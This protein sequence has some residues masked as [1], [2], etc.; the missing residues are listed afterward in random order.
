MA[1]G[2]RLGRRVHPRRARHLRRRV[3]PAAV[4]GDTVVATGR[5]HYR[6]CPTARSCAPSRTA[7]SCASTTPDAAG[8]SRSTSS[9]VPDP[10]AASHPRRALGSFSPHADSFTFA[11]EPFPAVQE[12]DRAGKLRRGS[13]AD[14]EDRVDGA[15]HEPRCPGVVPLPRERPVGPGVDVAASAARVSRSSATAA[16]TAATVAAASAPW[17]T[18]SA[19]R[20]RSSRATATSSRSGVVPVGAVVVGEQH[21]PDRHRVDPVGPQLRHEHEVALGLAAS[22]RPRTRPWPGA[23]SAG[24]RRRR[25]QRAAA[26][27]ALISWCGKTRSEPPPLTSNRWPR[28][29][30]EIA[31]HSMCQPG[32]PGPSRSSS[33][34]GLARALGAPQQGV[35]PACL[36]HPVGVAA[37]VGEHG[38]HLL[39]RP[40]GDVPEGRGLREVEVDVA[41][42]ALT[43]PGRGGGMP[44][45]T[46]AAP[47]PP[48]RICPSTRRRRRARRAAAPRA[49]SSSRNRSISEVASSRQSRP[50]RAA[51]EERVVDVGD[52]LDVLDAAAGARRTRPTRSNVMYVAAWPRWVAS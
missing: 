45:R 34:A 19:S 15:R 5:S 42:A 48:P 16:R 14:A 10:G 50:S 33:H 17:L 23:R 29:S 22:S 39:R 51:L 28:R 8:S 20:Q 4:D 12:V 11:G 37:A 30:S 35:E 36:P 40:A 13:E 18:E 2:G 49:P 46:R 24:R 41:A 31:V 7:S 52:V 44:C 43:P 26:W 3:L 38:I 9:S 21:E 6:R 47:A 25:R 1:R 27:T 32:R